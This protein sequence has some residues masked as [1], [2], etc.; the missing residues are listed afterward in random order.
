MV[1]VEELVDALATFRHRH[2]VPAV[3]GGV[4]DRDGP[5]RIEVIGARRRD[6]PADAATVDDV[7]HIGSCGKAITAVLY[8]RLV[9]AG[10]AEWG[11]PV[12]AL[13]PDLP[14]IPSSWDRPTIDD[15]LRSRAG[16]A[17]NPTRAE[18]PALWAS[19]APPDEQRTDTVRAALSVE[20]DRPGRFRYS[21]LGYVVAGAAIDRCAGMPFE[22]AL[23]V[24]VLDPLGIESLGF[25]PPPSVCGHGSRLRLGPLTVGKGAAAP[26]D[27]VRSDN[28]TLFTPAGRMHLTIDDWARFHRVFLREGAPLLSADTVRHLLAVPEDDRRSMSMGWASAEAIGAR[29]GMQ[30]SNTMWAATALIDA[31]M[32]RTAMVVTNDGRSRLLRRSAELA[33]RLLDLTSHPG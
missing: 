6:E 29:Y 32:S 1:D 27:D 5:S 12:R 13:F 21:N 26:P 8:A 10:R 2:G 33:S 4:V 14:G 23:R 25:G 20:P 28:P 9:E 30:G 18:M 17:P 16:V 11:T 22:E 3:I 24:H 31:T 15:L 7:W 19:S